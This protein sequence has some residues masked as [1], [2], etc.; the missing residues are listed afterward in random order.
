MTIDVLFMIQQ[1]A[2]RYHV[3]T[4]ILD[5]PECGPRSFD[6]GLRT[7]ILKDEKADMV[8]TNIYGGCKAGILYHIQDR[9][10][11][12]YDVFAFPENERQYG[13]YLI[14]G[15]Y[16]REVMDDYQL[17]TL[18]QKL[19]L[20]LGM[21]PAL[22]EYFFQVPL[23]LDQ[24]PWEELVLFFMYTLYGGQTIEKK[25]MH[26][27]ESDSR[28]EDSEE[29]QDMSVRVRVIEERYRLEGELLDAISSGDVTQAFKVCKR[30]SVRTIG[31][32]FKDP[33]RDRRNLLIVSNTIYRKAAERGC[34]H[35]FYIDQLSS[36]F[37]KKIEA[38]CTENQA[39]NL[40]AEMIRKYCHLVKNHSLKGHSPII[41]KIVNHITLNI[42]NDL[43][44]KGLADQ[45]CVNPSYLS[46]LFKK[47]MGMTVTS[48]IM[49]QRMKR[50]ILYLNTTSLHIQVI[51]SEVGIPD[52]NYFS[53]L[54]KKYTG[55]TPS[56][57][58]KNL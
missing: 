10:E 43:S 38:V 47:E 30:F 58:R 14:I 27:V 6:L 5:S 34:V 7:A 35:P 45:Y 37:A 33:N 55:L 31:R 11:V 23:I 53:K 1:I 8:V 41:Q 19:G 36:G 48:F 4:A 42:G 17:N 15:P 21:I 24:R 28:K 40:A 50:A 51:A 56:E 32:R 44:L 12:E 3:N 39:N 16:R 52:M 46:A 26:L 29:E 20:P 57:Y 13:D 22:K 54:F 2:R 49:E 25:T 18:V 9:F